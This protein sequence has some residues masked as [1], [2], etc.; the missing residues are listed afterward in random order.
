LGVGPLRGRL[1]SL[2]LSS[3]GS[4]RPLFGAVSH[5]ALTL[6]DEVLTMAN[7]EDVKLVSEAGDAE[8]VHM[9]DLIRTYGGL[10]SSDP[11]LSDDYDTLMAKWIRAKERAEGAASSWIP[12]IFSSL[13]DSYQDLLAVKRAIGPL[14]ARAVHLE[15]AAGRAGDAAPRLIPSGTVAKVQAALNGLRVPPANAPLK[16]DNILGNETRKALLWFQAGHSLPQTGRADAATLSALSVGS[17][18]DVAGERTMS[19]MHGVPL[20]PFAG[21]MAT[22]VALAAAWHAYKRYRGM[23]APTVAAV[24][25]VPSSVP[26]AAAVHGTFG[27]DTFADLSHDPSSVARTQQQLNQLGWRLA[28][29]GGLGR[30]TSHAIASFQQTHGMSPTGKLDVVTSTLIDLAATTGAS[31]SFGF[32]WTTYLLGLGTLPLVN[33]AKQ[34][35]HNVTGGPAGRMYGEDDVLEPWEMTPEPWELESTPTENMLFGDT[36][37]SLPADNLGRVRF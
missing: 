27:I 17:S 22:T 8:F 32:E 10:R 19:S 14:Y 24:P 7:R 31:P 11:G 2:R 34:Y 23:H 12:G 33:V 6:H 3:V 18:T 25:G 4:G 29:D 13:S 35:V 1:L 26:A 37:M 21:G 9:H 16:V 36:M 5:E 30:Q 20:L 28:V 15:S